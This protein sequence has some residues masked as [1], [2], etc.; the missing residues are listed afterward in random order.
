MPNQPIL[1]F[2]FLI[3]QAWEEG[4]SISQLTTEI[5]EA[6]AKA[7]THCRV[8]RRLLQKLY[9]SSPKVGLNLETCV[10][11]DSY[12]RQTGK[13]AQEVPLLAYPGVVDALV[14]VMRVQFLYG[15]KPRPKER[16]V[17]VSCWD[18]DAGAHILTAASRASA[19]CEFDTAHVLWRS[20]ASLKTVQSERW[21]HVLKDD[22]DSVVSIGSPLASLSTEVMLAQMFGVD[23][24]R[25]PAAG[26]ACKLPFRF[27][28]APEVAKD[29]RT[30]FA[31]A[32]AELRV[33]DPEIAAR[34]RANQSHAFY[35]EGKVHEVRR[36]GNS[37]LMHGIV[38]AQRRAAGNLWLVVSGL[39]GPA[40]CAAAKMVQDIQAILPWQQH[41]V[42]QVLWVP[43]LAH[44]RE[45]DANPADGDIRELCKV[46][47]L[48]QPRLRM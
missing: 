44:V 32:P 28:W 42:S 27:C 39:A 33:F 4:K 23:P 24:F 47:L 14:R 2:S 48:G 34:V 7:R 22:Q 38:A 8:N 17:D 10:A 16:R 43:V 21:Y 36:T 11:L 15:A 9:V 20:P 40:T 45:G 46:E 41:Q 1:Y 37:W 30:A 13:I 31:L 19:K 6:N 3:R 26:A 35:L 5:N 29:V 18:L 25:P 12:F